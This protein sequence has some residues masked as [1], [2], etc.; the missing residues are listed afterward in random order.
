MTNRKT[1]LYR[2]LKQYYAKA[3]TGEPVDRFPRSWAMY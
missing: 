2:K 3:K 1:A